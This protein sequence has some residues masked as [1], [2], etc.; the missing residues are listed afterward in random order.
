M[1]FKQFTTVTYDIETPNVPDFLVEMDPTIEL[2]N[3][4]GIK[5]TYRPKTGEVTLTYLDRGETKGTLKNGQLTIDVYKPKQIETES[6]LRASVLDTFEL[7]KAFI[8]ADDRRFG[9]LSIAAKLMVTQSRQLGDEQGYVILNG[10]EKLKEGTNTFGKHT[11]IR[12]GDHFVIITEYHVLVMVRDTELGF[13]RYTVT[14][15]MMS[16]KTFGAL[17]ACYEVGKALQAMSD[18]Y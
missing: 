14:H 6:Y 8:K 18:I 1:F 3:F 10:L 15:D 13:P 5:G 2:P 17:T 9:G 4:A 11:I 16:L 7:A 12:S